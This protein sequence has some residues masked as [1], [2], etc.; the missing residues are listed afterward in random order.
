M[1][2]ASRSIRRTE[3]S[4]SVV[5]DEVVYEIDGSYTAGTADYYS[6]ALGGYLPGDP[7][8]VEI[9]NIVATDPNGVRREMELDDLADD[10]AMAIEEAVAQAAE[11][12]ARCAAE[13]AAERRAELAPARWE[14]R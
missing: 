14:A 8:E 3:V 4:T 12:Q 9:E 1:K 2:N 7:A 10:E 6:T 11:D 5:L 13:D